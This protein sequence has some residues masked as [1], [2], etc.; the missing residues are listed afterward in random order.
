MLLNT[1]HVS[2]SIGFLLVFAGLCKAQDT[3]VPNMLPEKNKII[4]IGQ[5]TNINKNKRSI[6]R[7]KFFSLLIG[8]NRVGLNNP[9]GMVSNS[10][11]NVIVADHGTNTLIKYKNKKGEMPSLLN[12]RNRDFISLVGICLFFDDNILFTDSYLNSVFLLKENNNI[13]KFNIKDTLIQPTGVAYSKITKEIWVVETAAHRIS[14]YNKQGELIRKIG[15]R[16]GAP[17]EFNYPTFI[18]IDK[19]GIIYVVDSLNF[20]IQIFDKTGKLISVFGKHGDGSGF[21]ARPKGIAV[22]SEG[23]IYVADALFHVIQIFDKKGGFLYSFGSQGRGD[24]QLWMP[25][26]IFIDKNDIIYVADSY[27][28]R[29]QIFKFIKGKD[30]K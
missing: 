25:A 11:A 1:K 21:F 9:V 18:W 6:F 20:R 12:K 27:N 28:S 19:L 5:I 16:G 23:N 17:G 3:L 24:N 15:K 13:S 30:G 14:A 7:K 29:I 8:D 26:G 10:A 2:F 22:D 4:K